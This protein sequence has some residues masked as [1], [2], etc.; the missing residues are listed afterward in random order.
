MLRGKAVIS[1]AFQPYLSKFLYVYT[2]PLYQVEKGWVATF[3]H[4]VKGLLW[5]RAVLLQMAL[6]CIGNENYD[7]S[8]EDIVQEG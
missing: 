7:Y 3:F 8:L 4:L 5:D 1:K 2:R 6:N